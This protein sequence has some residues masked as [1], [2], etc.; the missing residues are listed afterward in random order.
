MPKEIRIIGS[1]LLVFIM[2]VSL[3]FVF[4]IN[5]TS[6]RAV[7]IIAACEAYRIRTGRYP[8]SL[9]S[10]VPNYL[11]EIPKPKTIFTDESFIYLATPR[12]N[13]LVY[14]VLSPFGQRIYSL[15]EKRW[16]FAN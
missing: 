14:E 2:A 15:Q 12:E 7:K 3:I 4:N 16:S 10:L 6:K 8:S 1:I 9:R 5:T 11:E 13:A